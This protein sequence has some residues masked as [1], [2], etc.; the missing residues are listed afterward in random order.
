MAT[1]EARMANQYPRYHGELVA[2]V[3]RL[4]EQLYGNLRLILLVL[5][6]AVAF[7][8]LIV[9]AN[10]ANLLLSRAAA[11][12]KE[13][14]LRSA[15][16][17][18]RQR[19]LRQ[20]LT[21]SMLLTILGGLAG[22]LLA[23]WGANLL[24][25]LSPPDLIAIQSVRISAPVLIFTLGVSLATGL[26]IG[27]APAYSA[28][29]LNI[30]DALKESG[31]SVADSRRNRRLRGLFVIAEIALAL[32]LLSGAG[33]LI[34]S[35]ARLQAVD[36]GFNPRDVLTIDV[37]VSNNWQM[38]ERQRIDFIKG[39]VERLKA[40][41]GVKGAGAVS[42]LPFAVPATGVLFTIE[43]RP[44][45]PPGQDLLTRVCPA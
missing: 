30:H 23:V 44:K 33:L 21:E 13:L 22:L 38:P 35:F 18:S 41:P 45:P 4:R 1:I 42:A 36:P 26:F 19:I 15:L 39:A 28:A 14:A 2:S 10:V 16:G 6:G 20:L 43:D 32:V 31:R 37:G 3:V 25:S 11:R 7:V 27:I 40:L 34:N 17:A 8:L 12:G 29:R 5:F 9:C 24:V